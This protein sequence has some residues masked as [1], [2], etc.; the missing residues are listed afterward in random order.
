[1][2]ILSSRFSNLAEEMRGQFLV[3]RPD[4]K[5]QKLDLYVNGLKEEKTKKRKITMSYE[6]EKRRKIDQTQAFDVKTGSN[7][8]NNICEKSKNFNTYVGE[9]THKFV[10]VNYGNL[11]KKL[12][13]KF[14]INDVHEEK[15]EKK[16]N[17]TNNF[18]K[19][20]SD[21][22]FYLPSKNVSK[23]YYTKNKINVGTNYDLK[24]KIFEKKIK[25]GNFGVLDS[26]E[27]FRLKMKL[28]KKE[29]KQR[30][31]DEDKLEKNEAMQNSFPY[32]QSQAPSSPLSPISSRVSSKSSCSSS[33]SSFNSSFEINESKVPLKKRITKFF[34][35]M[36]NNEVLRN[37]LLFCNSVFEKTFF[38]LILILFTAILC[39]GC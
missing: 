6:F 1:M 35:E 38:H 16:I 28:S 36:E 29:L 12:G 31:R 17:L 30:R 21:F 25:N 22:T 24:V 15:R 4:L 32:Y 33:P 37:F 8:E 26:L 27:R 14:K 10:S 19:Y 34:Y 23:I 39:N 2:P 3:S 11:E 20:L 13:S 7:A 5:L 9:K 18:T